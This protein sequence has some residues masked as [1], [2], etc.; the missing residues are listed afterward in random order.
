VASALINRGKYI[1]FLVLLSLLASLFFT[2]FLGTTFGTV[3]GLKFRLNIQPSTSGTTVLSIPPLGEIKAKTHQTPFK[4]KVSLEKINIDRLKTLVLESSNQKILEELENDAYR[5]GN[6]FLIRLLIIAS[7]GAGLTALLV[8]RNLRSALTGLLVGFFFTTLVVGL[9]YYTFD[10]RGFRQ[11]QYT[12]VLRASPWI[13]GAI[14][15]RFDTVQAFR[16]EVRNI[17]TN[18]YRFYSKIESWKPI[19]L[20]KG[21]IAILHVSDIHNNPA[22]IELVKQVVEEF[23]VSLII[24]TGDVT[25]F[26]SPIEADLVSSVEKLKVPYLYVPGN[27]DSPKVIEKLRTLKNIT[28]LGEKPVRKKDLLIMGVPDPL[29]T[30]TEV[31]PLTDQKMDQKAKQLAQKMGF[32]KKKPFIFAVHDGRQAAK[33]VGKVPVVL[34]GHTHRVKIKNR[35]ET[36][37]INAGTTGA[38]G[39]R[40]FE[41]QS[42]VPNTLNILYIKPDVPELLAVDTVEVMGIEREF[43]LRRTLIEENANGV[44]VP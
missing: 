44:A 29:S 16:E 21:A 10:I 13:M 34:M 8:F 31:K 7:L 18:V 12:G 26:G 17:A 24:D 5:V 40:T 39:L 38:A 15:Q 37:L 25:D 43:V 42:G 4:L 41:V 3:N 22:A 27:H 23:S 14:R 1:V 6:R 11:P 9:T 28:V 32:L 20:E 33:I 36:I 30:K 2:T 35:K 19:R